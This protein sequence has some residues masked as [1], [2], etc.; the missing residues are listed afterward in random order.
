MKYS[1]L[2]IK[3]AVRW[4]VMNHTKKCYMLGPRAFDLYDDWF[5]SIRG[6]VRSAAIR[7]LLRNN[8]VMETEKLLKRIHTLSNRK[9]SPIPLSE[10]Q[11]KTAL[12]G[13]IKHTVLREVEIAY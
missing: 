8:G 6:S 12:R 5:F 10:R 3:H 7:I 9:S 13:L 4:T 2:N 1:I 11:V